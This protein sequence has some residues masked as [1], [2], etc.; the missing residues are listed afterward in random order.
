[1]GIH[2][3]IL[4]V[5]VKVC[6]QTMIVVQHRG[7]T[8]KA[9]AI[10]MVFLQPELQ[11]GQQEVQ[12]TGSAVVKTFWYPMRDARPFHHRGRTAKWFRQTY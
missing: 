7:D 10:E 12:Y 5:G 6:T 2:R 9:E 4:I 8:V 11:I 1:M 3:E